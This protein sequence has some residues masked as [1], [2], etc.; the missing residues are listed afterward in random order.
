MDLGVG[1]FE[2][3]ITDSALE[4]E[5]PFPAL[6]EDFTPQCALGEASHG[7]SGVNYGIHL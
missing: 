6:V 1:T 7:G 2:N 5:C 3:A 4:G